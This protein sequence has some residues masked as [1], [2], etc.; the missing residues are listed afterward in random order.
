MLTDLGVARVLG[1]AAAA[2][3]TPPYVDPTVARGGAPGPASDV[4]GVA[5]AAFHALTGV[6]PWNAATPGGHARRRGGGCLPDS[7]TGAGGPAGLVAVIARGLSPDPHAAGAAAFALDLR[8][9]SGRRR[10]GCRSTASRTRSWAGRPG[11]R[12]ELTDQVP[13]PS[14]PAPTVV[15]PTPGAEGRR[16]PGL[17]R[18]PP[19]ARLSPPSGRGPAAALVATLAGAGGSGLR[20]AAAPGG[21]GKPVEATR[22]PPPGQSGGPAGPPTPAGAAPTAGEA[23]SAR[24]TAVVDEL[25]A[26]RARRLRRGSP[27]CSTASTRRA[28]R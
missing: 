10:C 7:R 28:A 18:V 27:D 8:H 2:E 16:G 15:P 1:E 21:G 20:W 22:W 25:Y 26:R 6:A 24:W 12:T 3:V 19:T 17:E 13:G 4:F 11:P 5:A 23:G 9:A 14:R